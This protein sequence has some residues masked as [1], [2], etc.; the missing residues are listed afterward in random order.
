[1]S[2]RRESMGMGR[3]N[4]C[5]LRMS[6]ATGGACR[7]RRTG[8][9]CLSSSTRTT[10]QTPTAPDWPSS[11]V[12]CI[13]RGRPSSYESSRWATACGS[14]RIFAVTPREPSLS[15]SRRDWRTRALPPMRS[16]NCDC[17]MPGTRREGDVKRIL[18]EGAGRMR[19]YCN[20]L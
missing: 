1:M 12:Q 17:R 19:R 16:R 10:I 5:L 15:A 3:E 14:H 8:A 20:G 9:A 18:S 7:K 4:S 13:Q 6:L 11:G 2:A